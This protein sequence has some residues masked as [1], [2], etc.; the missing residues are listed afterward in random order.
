MHF[1][2]SPV[3]VVCLLVILVTALVNIYAHWIEDG[4]VGRMLYMAL[5]F[6]SVAGLIRYTSA[7]I[8]EHLTSTIVVLY[9][10]LGIRSLAVK[11]TRYIKYRRTIHAKNNQR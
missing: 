4:L 7:S 3:G 2:N 10:L 11:S 5:A 8:P 6:T 1:I 9:S